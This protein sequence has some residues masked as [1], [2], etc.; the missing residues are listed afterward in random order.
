M[1]EAPPPTLPADRAQQLMAQ[2]AVLYGAELGAATYA[3]LHD[4]LLQCMADQPSAAFQPRE[5]LARLTA[6]DAMV[7]T[8]G[9][10]VQEA[11]RA[12]LA[13]LDEWLRTH[14]GNVISSVHLLPFY[15]YS[16]DDGFSV[17]DYSAV[18]PNLGAWSD[19]EGLSRHYKL[20]FDAVIN[21]ISAH[22]AWFQ[23]F[24]E[25][26]AEYADYFIVVDDPV[27]V[28]LVTRPRTH[29]LLTRFQT[30]TGPHNVWTTFSADQ[31]DLNFGNPDVLLAIIDVLL[32]Y[33]AQGATYLRLDAIG[34]LWKT[35]G[36]TCIHLHETHTVVQLM[37][38]VLDVVAPQVLLITET[39]VP[40]VDNISYFGNGYNEAQLVYQFSLAPLTLH[41]FH[42]GS[43][44]YLQQW[45]ADL[46]TPSP[47]TT[48]FNFLA[49]HDGI[50]VVPAKGILS[51]T[52]V[53][54][55]AQITLDHGGRVSYKTNPDGSQSAYEL[56]ITLFDALSNPDSTPEAVAIDRFIAANAIMLALAGLPGIYLHSLVGSRND[57]AGMART[58]HNRTINRKKW[59]RADIDAVLADP[60]SREA[61]VLRRYLH[62]LRCRA[63]SPAFD[64]NSLQQVI[65]GPDG[66]FSLLRTTRD[67]NERVVC[68]HNVTGSAQELTINAS[69]FGD[70]PPR[71]L[72]DLLSD[73][74]I[75]LDAAGNATISVAPY[76][77]LWLRATA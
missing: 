42:T 48:F 43:T 39:N 55:L 38:S 75:A 77:I 5:R 58:G 9:D 33:V 27:D 53:D 46:A 17:I 22:S 71:A 25:G 11:G 54:A 56:N 35:L 31:I 14:L 26:D 74:R 10:Q 37:R 68:I 76:E 2:L 41:A 12:P 29:P 52:E 40:H 51:A 69:Q 13:T 28:S 7:I 15:P 4:R 65:P 23:S 24:L 6:A 70:T 67:G 45:A 66:V 8:Y 73:R 16:S 20:M 19:V 63:A 50:G 36:T 32:L 59:Q 18:D 60:Q 21:H 72:H 34:Y 44:R 1:P 30:A 47:D 64:V 49:S 61:N 62:L 57:H 3:R